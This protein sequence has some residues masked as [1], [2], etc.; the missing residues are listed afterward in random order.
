[1]NTT[2]KPPTPEEQKSIESALKIIHRI[3]RLMENDDFKWFMNYHSEVAFA[4]AKSIL[5]D[6]ME[7]E[8][9]EAKRQRR[10]GIISVW[11]SLQEDRAAQAGILRGFGINPG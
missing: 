1:M 2:P 6:D 11:D 7:P 5:N 4:M 8:K 9:R 3:D 10:L